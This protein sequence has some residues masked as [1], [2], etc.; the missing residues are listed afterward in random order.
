MNVYDNETNIYQDLNPTALQKPQSYRLNKLSKID[1]CF[2]NETEVCEQ[3]GKKMK[4]FNA[5]TGIVDTGLIT[6]TVT[7]GG[8]LLKH[9][10][11]VL[12]CL[13]VLP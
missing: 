9:L 12:D 3:I 13:F 2:L 7:T 1:A 10:P 6:S 11:V 8:Y 4:R 5:I